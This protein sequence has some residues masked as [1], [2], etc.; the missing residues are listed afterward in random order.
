MHRTKLVD[1]GTPGAGAA[2][3][4]TGV[5]SVGRSKIDRILRSG[6]VGACGRVDAS[7]RRGESSSEETR[8]CRGALLAWPLVRGL[9]KLCEFSK[10]GRLRYEAWSDV[11]TAGGQKQ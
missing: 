4:N 1:F 8:L 2:L 3:R 6:V 10:S 9:A 11:I 7:F 5:F